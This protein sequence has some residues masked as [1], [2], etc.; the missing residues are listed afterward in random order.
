MSTTASAVGL[1]AASKYT[2]RNVWAH[3]TSVSTNGQISNVKQWLLVFEGADSLGADVAGML[4]VTEPI[5]RT[6]QRPQLASVRERLVA[7]AVR[8]SHRNASHLCRHPSR[9]VRT[10]QA[11]QGRCLAP[12]SELTMDTDLADTARSALECVCS[13]AEREAAA[14]YYSP[15]FVDHVNDIELRGLEGVH[16]SVE[17]YT[18]VLDDLQV[19]VEEQLIDGDRVTSRFVVTGTSRG[20]RVRF[21]GITIS[22]FRDGKIIEDWSVTDTLGMLRQLGAWRSVVLAVRQWRAL[23]GRSFGTR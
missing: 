9:G 12:R 14:R 15:E 10:D 22:H 4:R 21:N 1:P 8:S 17:L 23:T 18:S 20:R 11:L 3:T 7:T 5:V 19:T 13:G 2:I 16:R 6:S